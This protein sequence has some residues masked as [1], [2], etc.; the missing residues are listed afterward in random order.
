[1]VVYIT[2]VTADHGWQWCGWDGK[3]KAGEVF[4]NPSKGKIP[5]RG[6]PPP[7]RTS[8]GQKLPENGVFRP[9]NTVFGPIF[10]I[11]FL[12]GKGGSPLPLE[13]DGRPKS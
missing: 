7:W 3:S 9:Q 4:K 6:Y 13:E 1:M 11:F 8:A 5:L 2:Q 12:S 10:N